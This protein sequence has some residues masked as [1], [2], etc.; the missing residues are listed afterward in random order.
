MSVNTAKHHSHGSDEI[1]ATPGEGQT[2]NFDLNFNVASEPRTG[3]RRIFCLVTRGSLQDEGGF[4]W[5]EKGFGGC[6]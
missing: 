5:K 2:E 6:Y 1:S 3:P 4:P